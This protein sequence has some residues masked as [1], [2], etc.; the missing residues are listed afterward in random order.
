VVAWAG[1]GAQAV[2][3][4]QDGNAE[5]GDA[6]SGRLE[7]ATAL[8]A[9][10]RF[11]EAL[12]E[13]GSYLEAHP[14]EA[15]A[16]FLEGVLFARTGRREAAVQ[17][18]E[19]LVIEYPESL[20]AWSNLGVL[21]AEGGDPRRGIE[22]IER[23]IATN[24]T[25]SAA[26]QNLRR[27]YAMYGA[28]SYREATRG[29]GLAD[30]EDASGGRAPASPVPDLE[31]IPSWGEGNAESREADS[32]RIPEVIIRA[33]AEAAAPGAAETESVA[34]AIYSWAERWSA[35]D[36]EGFLRSYSSAF[37]P[38]SGESVA[39]WRAARRAELATPRFIQ[40]A[41]VG[42][43]I[44]REGDRAVATFLERYRSDRRESETPRRLELQWEEGSWR[45]VEE[46]SEESSPVP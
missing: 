45:I 18:F 23:G 4:S 8:Q 33:S 3:Q 21:Y 27:V 39:A 20:E 5:T 37:V 26:F 10:G 6:S 40:V 2:G 1:L 36:L 32:G 11:E 41:V 35:Q 38:G 9:A 29:A 7:T 25:L 31:L 43:E 14:G 46:S 30:A 16:R 12:V 24:P 28:S 44:S 22:A 42:L 19:S 34:A 15:R 13:V 17:R